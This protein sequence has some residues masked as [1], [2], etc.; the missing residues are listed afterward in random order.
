MNSR[1]LA[2]DLPVRPALG[3]EAF[4]VSPANA[5]ALAAIDAWTTWPGRRHLLV[6]PA[7]SG[8]THL[9]HVWA[10][11]SGARIVAARDIGTDDVPA[12]AAAPAVTVEDI[13]READEAALFHLLNLTLTEGTPLLLTA[14][15]HPNERPPALPD[16]ASRLAAMPVARLEPPDDAL[17]QAVLVKLFE[18]RQITV[19][20]DVISYLLA[21]IERSLDAARRTVSALDAAA[22]AERRPVTRQLARSILDKPGPDSA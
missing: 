7:G 10:A 21:R 8:K 17:L 15:V 12:L 3:R 6:G 18:D 20:P 11:L 22:L 2:L 13:D 1:Q 5:N 19:S 9:A 4:F 14:T 16:L